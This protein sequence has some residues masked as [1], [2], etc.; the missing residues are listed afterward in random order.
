MSGLYQRTSQSLGGLLDVD[1]VNSTNDEVLTY[2]DELWK[3]KPAGGGG[4]VYGSAT[5]TDVIVFNGNLD[6]WSSQVATGITVA[7]TLGDANVFT[8]I[9]EGWYSLGFSFQLK[10]T[11]PANNFTVVTLTII[12][13][14]TT[15][16]TLQDDDRPAGR[17]DNNISITMGGTILI[18]LTA[19]QTITFNV[20]VDSDNHTVSGFA[21]LVKIA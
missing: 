6:N 7:N 14:G 3:N 19:G 16:H 13:S 1:L 2:E 4:A 12:R 15:I 9:T 21:S 17:P 5:I 10:G 18:Q 8:A 11:N 20:T